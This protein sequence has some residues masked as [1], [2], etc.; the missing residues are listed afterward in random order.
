MDAAIY[1][2]VVCA[3]LFLGLPSFM[4]VAHLVGFH[5]YLANLGLTTYNYVMK[6]Q[7]EEDAKRRSADKYLDES[8]ETDS[9]EIDTDEEEPSPSPGQNEGAGSDDKAVADDKGGGA[10]VASSKAPEGVI[11]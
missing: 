8:T 10:D 2:S 4:M 11:S 3:N 7:A 9:D 5:I 1:F 6:M